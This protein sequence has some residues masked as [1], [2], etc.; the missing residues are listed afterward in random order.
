MKKK[1]DKDVFPAMLQ[2]FNEAT[3]SYYK[4]I[5]NQVIASSPIPA[6]P[7]SERALE[8]IAFAHT[9]HR[10]I[11]VASLLDAANALGF[12]TG[13]LHEQRTKSDKTKGAKS[14][15]KRK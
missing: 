3:L 9:F 4:A 6:R 5:A 12:I 13:Q 1:H 14:K 11:T 15:G 7:P 8:A 10:T 2:S